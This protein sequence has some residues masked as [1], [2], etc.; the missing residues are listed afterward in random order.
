MAIVS[1]VQHILGH[2]TPNSFAK[3]VDT[4]GEVA[5]P[6]MNGVGINLLGAWRQATGPIG[7]DLMISS[8]ESMAEMEEILPKL[9]QHEALTEGLP[10]LMGLGFTID[11]VARYG[12]TLPFADDRRLL[13]G[14]NNPGT[15]PRSYRL[16]RRRANSDGI[17]TAID[18]LSDLADGLEAAGS[19]KL[20]TAYVTTGGDRREI[21]EIWIAD[22]VSLEWYAKAASTQTLAALD[23]V[24]LDASIHFL[25][26]LPYSNAR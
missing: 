21:S 16:I 2:S 26:P 4:Y 18:A 3:Y 11:E 7:R 24:T 22:D 12:R 20:F 5:I 25:E 23:A 8:F 13:Q 15:K 19:W 9:L 6:A 10:R 1:E 14:T 17:A